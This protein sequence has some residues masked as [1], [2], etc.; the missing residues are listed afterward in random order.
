MYE[1]QLPY[2]WTY[3]LNDSSSCVVFCATQEIFDS[4]H[5]NVL[6]ST[7]SVK[8]SV[9]LDAPEGEPHAFAT[10]MAAHSDSEGS[11]IVKPAPDDLANLIYT[12]GTTGQ[13]KGTSCK[14]KNA[15]TLCT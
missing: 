2:D 6:P 5:K 11:L 9:C 8:A 12:S 7:P 1:A 15:N 10:L 13:P 4:V 14:L 3:I